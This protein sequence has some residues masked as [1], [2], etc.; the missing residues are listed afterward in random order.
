MASPTQTVVGKGISN[1]LTAEDLLKI[2]KDL[3]P[4]I[5]SPKSLTN[6]CPWNGKTTQKGIHIPCE[7]TSL[8]Y[9][10]NI[11]PLLVRFWP[12]PSWI[13]PM[14][15][16]VWS[17]SRVNKLRLSFPSIE[18]QVHSDYCY[19]QTPLTVKWILVKLT[20]HLWQVAL[21]IPMEF[22]DIQFFMR[23]IFLSSPTN[24]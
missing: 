14:S 15:L 8:T 19:V 11:R 22:S 18:W 7:T 21:Q 2:L 12:I 24:L 16:R 20:L 9:H 13:K 6:S 10:V 1:P 4:L 17:T 3:F 5:S 23:F